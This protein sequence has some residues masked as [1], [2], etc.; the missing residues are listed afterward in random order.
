MFYNVVASD[1][2]DNPYNN[3]LVFTFYELDDALNFVKTLFSVSDYVVE[4]VK[5]K[6]D[7]GE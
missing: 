1:K 3:Q 5:I 7:E 2:L 4:I 6:N